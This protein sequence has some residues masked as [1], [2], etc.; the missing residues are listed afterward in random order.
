MVRVGRDG[1]RQGAGG[2]SAGGWPLPETGVA[3]PGDRRIQVTE[4]EARPPTRIPVELSSSSPDDRF[5]AV[6]EMSRD[7]IVEVGASGK[8]LYVSPGFSELTGH[9]PEVATAG[10]LLELVHAD[11]RAE[12]ARIRDEAL[13]EEV[14]ARL[15][16]RYRH[17]DGDWRWIGVAARPFRN[18][19][20]ELRI[21]LVGSEETGSDPRL[22]GQ[23]DAE[24]QIG[25]LSRRLLQLEPEHF[26]SGLYGC[27]EEAARL[28]EAER[29]QFYVLVGHDEG[30]GHYQW[31]VEGGG[32][33]PLEELEDAAR[34]FRWTTRQLLGGCEVH[35]SDTASLP[36]EAAEERTFFARTGTL[37]YLALPIMQ[38]GRSVGFM[39]FR[40]SRRRPDWTE[41]DVSRLRLLAELFTNAV[42]RLRAERRTRESERR[43]RLLT[44][45]LQ[46]T[47]CE[48]GEDGRVLYLSPNAEKLCGYRPEELGGN[49]LWELLHPRDRDG[50]RS[51]ITEALSNDGEVAP[52]TYRIQHRDGQW[53]WLEATVR[54]FRTASSE[55]RLAISVRDVTERQES[56]MELE[57]RL[58]LESRIA[59]FSRVLME[60]GAG[61]IEVGI[62]E[63]LGLAGQLTGADRAFL[64]T[65]LEE[66]GSRPTSYEW[67]LPDVEPRSQPFGLPD[68]SRQEWVRA[69]LERGEVVKVERVEDMPAEARSVQASLLE[70]GIRS[71]LVV[72]ILGD[73]GLAG[74]LGFHCLRQAQSWSA[75][76]VNILRLIADLF[77]S[78]LRRKRVESTLRENEIRLLQAQKMEAI[79]TLA[80]GIAHDFNNQ[81]TVMLANARFVRSEVPADGEVALAL[82]D[83]TRAAEHCAQLT[84]S[85]LAFSRRSSVST[86]ALDAS[87][88]L[89]NALELLRP[90]VPSSIRFEAAAEPD[91]GWIVA[92]ST[93]LQQVLVNL[94][95]NARDAMQGRGTLTLRASRRHLEPGEAERIGLAKGGPHVEFLVRDTGPGMDA[96]VKARIFEPF[97]TTKPLGQGTGLGL[98]TAYGIVQQAN[99]AITVETEPGRGSTFCVFLP[100]ALEHEAKQVAAAGEDEEVGSGTVLLAE[101]EE[102]V[103]RITARML[104]AG[105]YEV[106]LASDGGEA[107][108]LGRQNADRLTAI[109][110][111]LEMPEV[112][113]LELAR[114][115]VRQR[116]ELPVVFIS[117]AVPEG[118][119]GASFEAPVPNGC[120]VPKPFTGPQL[121]AA[122]RELLDEAPSEHQKR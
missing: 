112:G 61:E 64:V 11:D 102:S 84:R 110:T 70:A 49:G 39:D 91:L 120:F 15:R 94:V 114:R 60:R 33:R 108:R 101:D 37:A 56:R 7:A 76:D 5:H 105:G 118:G 46:D 72:P 59:D 54:G 96:E 74:V 66:D 25:R 19:A 82:D 16:F 47:I 6:A 116:P 109:V 75:H 51:R 73:D 111:D 106:L 77:H 2:P 36:D 35:V 90:L 21:V 40:R 113:G 99:G 17:R 10:D 83:V 119:T 28:A 80:G 55:R 115:L 50:T 78:A 81:L 98:A 13:R 27:L 3:A 4:P 69:Q 87:D 57:R 97:F 22:Q 26:E 42:R 95:V 29:V 100:E 45:E 48:I 41:A 9:P 86:R 89:A 58:E 31:S 79:G 24:R 18:D 71:Y 103:R 34:R 38:N 117:G 14:P 62:H 68:R 88:E 122:L 93:Q 107:L 43:L 53:R 92:D 1:D 85:L 8:V 20:G 67:A 121:L 23:L 52:L 104:R 44:S 32:S 12:L 30:L 63:G 65:A